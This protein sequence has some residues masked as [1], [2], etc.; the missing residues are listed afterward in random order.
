MSD[1]ADKQAQETHSYAEVHV[2]ADRVE[3]LIN[4]W[5]SEYIHNSPVSRSVEAVNHVRSSLGALRDKL[6]KEG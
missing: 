3:E 1:S 4:E 5:F 6:V 2:S